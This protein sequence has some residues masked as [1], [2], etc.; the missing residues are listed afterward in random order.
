MYSALADQE[1]I[2]PEG[3]SQP[4]LE[5]DCDAVTVRTNVYH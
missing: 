2:Y 4:K 1:A 3:L 5:L